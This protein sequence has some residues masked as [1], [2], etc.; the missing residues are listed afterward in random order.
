MRLHHVI[1]AGLATA[2]TL[3]LVIAN[4]GPTLQ[5]K[6]ATAPANYMPNMSRAR[7]ELSRSSAS[8]N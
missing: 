1:T 8:G 3:A 5:G 4:T 6:Y 2:A 7:A